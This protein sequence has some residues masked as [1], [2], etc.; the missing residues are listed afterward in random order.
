MKLDAET[1]GQ[2]RFLNRFFKLAGMSMESRPRQWLMPAERTL[3][4]ADLAPGQTVLE[5]G[6]G[7]GFFTVPAARMIGDGGHLIA[8]EPLSDFADRVREKVGGA[9]LT[10]VE[11]IRRD[12]L[13]TELEA[14]TID[15][16]LLFGVVPFPTLPLDRLLPEM[17]RV[18]KPDGMLAAWLWPTTAGVPTAILRSG[19]FAD[20]GKKNG[21]HRYRRLDAG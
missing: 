17:H 18:L 15:V 4:G 6:S 10:N 2:S 13:K 9:G 16:V 20:L 5:V 8:M 21:V 14:A 3:R 19:L 7:T 12:A 11:V 1:L